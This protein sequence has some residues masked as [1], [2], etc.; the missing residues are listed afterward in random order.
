[1]HF[2]LSTQRRYAVRS[3]NRHPGALWVGGL[4]DPK[5]GLGIVM[6]LLRNEFRLRSPWLEWFSCPALTVYKKEDSVWFIA[7]TATDFTHYTSLY[8]PSTL[9]PLFK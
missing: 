2:N 1:M 9:F 5:V 8:F 3:G 7:W 4:V 6:H